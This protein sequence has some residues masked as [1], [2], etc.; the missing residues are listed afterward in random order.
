VCHSPEFKTCC[1][2]QNEATT[3]KNKALEKGNALQLYVYARQLQGE[4][5]QDE[6]LA[7]Y[8]SNAKKFP[9]YWTTHLGMARV[10]SAAGDYNAVKEMKLALAGSPDAN[11]SALEN[12][13]ERLQAKDDINK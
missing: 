7:V 9:E 8:R 3:F 2:G 5:K 12:Y 4:K 6:A 11:K 1:F 10:Y 13:V